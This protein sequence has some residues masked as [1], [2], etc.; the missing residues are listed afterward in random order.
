M[1]TS[2]SSG[3]GLHPRPSVTAAARDRR[4]LALQVRDQLQEVLKR[5]G[6]SPGDQLPSE[7]ELAQRFAVAR[8]TVREALKLL[9]QDG[10]V[11]VQHGRGRF[12]SAIAG[13]RV[14]RPIT[15]FESVTEMMAGLGYSVTSRILSLEEAPASHEEAAALRLRPGDPVIRLERLRLQDG[16]TLIF[17]FNAI[18]RRVIP[19]PLELDWSGSVVELLGAHGH[20][21]VSSVA[22]IRAAFLPRAVVKK[23]SEK[24]RA[25]WLLIIETCVTETGEPCLYSRDYH[26]ADL[27]NF[28]VLRR[29]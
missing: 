10:L 3:S 17:S 18:D 1:P 25:P 29:R 16:Q 23:V 19:N 2:D 12:L 14:E 4:P 8:T 22:Q 28:H 5:D 6:L 7:T 15:T 13:L 24:A 21:L 20:R 9:E 11:D 26:R 27:F